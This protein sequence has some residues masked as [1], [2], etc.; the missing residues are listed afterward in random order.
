MYAAKTTKALQTHDVLRR[1]LRE[2]HWSTGAIG[3]WIGT[4]PFPK[5]LQTTCAPN[6]WTMVVEGYGGVNAENSLESELL[7]AVI[8]TLVDRDIL[9][10]RPPGSCLNSLPT[11]LNS[12][13]L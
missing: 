3:F 6:D 1:E 8:S 11:L 13:L 9:R 4:C 5:Q 2:R 10:G 7:A 12:F